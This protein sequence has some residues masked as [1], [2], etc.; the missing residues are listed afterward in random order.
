MPI[1]IFAASARMR[2]RSAAEISVTL[3]ATVNGAISTKSYPAFFANAKVSSIDQ[4]LKISLQIPNFIR[5]HCRAYCAM[6]K[7]KVETLRR[8]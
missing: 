2:A 3:F 7:R 4:S 1:P 5:A 8:P 6:G